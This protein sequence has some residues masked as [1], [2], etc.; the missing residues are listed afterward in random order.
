MSLTNEITMANILIIA[1]FIRLYKYHCLEN[2]KQI[3]ETSH[4]K[5]SGLMSDLIKHLGVD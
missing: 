1:S 2:W 4:Q 3:S 5:G